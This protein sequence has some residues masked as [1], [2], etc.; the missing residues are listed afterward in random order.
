[1]GR[2]IVQRLILTIPVLIGIMLVCFFLTRLSGDPTDL[3]L[4]TNATEEA[5]AAFRSVHGL[6]KPLWEQFVTFFA[7]GLMGDFGSSLRFNQPA[8]SLVWERLGATTELAAATMAMALFIGVPA[9][10]AA[11]Y[12]RNT[13]ADITIRGI[14]LMGQA[15][16][17][18]YLGIISI[19][20]FAVWLRWLPSGG[21]GSWLNLILPAATLAF[22]LVALIAR[23]TRSC[24]LDVLRQDYIRTARAKGARERTVL[25]IHA[26]RNGFIPVL[27]V[28]GLQV[29]LLMGGVVVTETVFSWPGVGRLAIQAIYARDF[30]VVQAVVFTFA[31]I[32]VFV[33]LVVD[34]LYAVLDPR[35]SYN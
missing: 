12:R 9:G 26:L 10:V 1:M 22:N 3:M 16:P 30:P 14:T 15:L 29:G 19:I 8:M 17:G 28:I 4:P 24:M 6:D 11:A 7:K 2:Y 20:V 25:W 31:I 21:R 5:R 33:N 34:L 18:F 13:P 23:V 35:I 27:T 32:F